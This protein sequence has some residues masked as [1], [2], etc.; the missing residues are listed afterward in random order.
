MAFLLKRI[1]AFD[2]ADDDDFLGAQLE[3]LFHL[4]RQNDAAFDPDRGAGEE[5]SDDV[6]VIEFVVIEYS[7]NELRGTGLFCN[8]NSVP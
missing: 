7:I 1:V 8:Q 5:V 3:R 6:V 2:F 4:G